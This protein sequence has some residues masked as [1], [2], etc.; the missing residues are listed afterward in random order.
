MFKEMG[1]LSSLPLCP[2]SGAVSAQH[3][4]RQGTFQPV[5]VEQP[6]LFII[7]DMQR[8]GG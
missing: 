3:G 2:F 1:T 5:H 7:R 4:H 8:E 6:G